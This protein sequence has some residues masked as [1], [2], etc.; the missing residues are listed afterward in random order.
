MY[1]H[2]LLPRL[3]AEHHHDPQACMTISAAVAEV[4]HG[5]SL[6]ARLGHVYHLETGPAYHLPKWP[7]LLFHVTSAPNGRT[8]NSWWEAD[9]LGP[10]WWPT[11]WEA[12]Q[13]EGIRAQFRGRG[14]IGDRSLPMLADGGPAGPRPEGPR[15]PKD[16]SD[17]IDQWKKSVE[18]VR[19]N[20][21]GR[22]G[23]VV[24]HYGGAETAGGTGPSD[25]SSAAR[26]G[27]GVSGLTLLGDSGTGSVGTEAGVRNPGAPGSEGISEDAVSPEPVSNSGQ[28]SS[29]A[30]DALRRVL[31]E[32]V[33]RGEAARRGATEDTSADVQH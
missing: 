28:P 6:L 24:V 17:L 10:G 20:G 23:E 7:R 22:W 26:L 30:V 14:G 9:E 12:Q 31:A 13:R 29:R 19:S 5:L 32:S 25:E 33:A 8:V 21:E 3:Q 16:N 27:E 2:E 18:N 1:L 4:E 11:L 15:A